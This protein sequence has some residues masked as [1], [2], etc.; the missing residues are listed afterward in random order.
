MNDVKSPILFLLLGALIIAGCDNADPDDSPVTSGILV[1]NQGNFSDGN[2]SV[3]LIDLA[4]SN[5]TTV[6]DGLA[7]IVQSLELGDSTFHVVA[8]TGGRV[9]V[10]SI[11]TGQRVGQI[12]G[13]T[14]PRY[15]ASLATGTAY[16]SNLFGAGFS[17]GTVSI[18]DLALQTVVKTIDVGNNPEGVAI[19]GG[20]VYVANNE[21][22]AG[23]TL[24]VISTTTQEV[25]GT[26]DV[27]CDGPRALAVDRE[28]EL[29][30][31][32]TG[33]T[34]YDNNFNVIGET[35]GEI[36]L[37]DGA[38]GT[39]ITRFP[40]TSRIGTAGPGQDAYYS[41]EEQ[42]LHVVLDQ[43]KVMR[44][45]TGANAIVD[46][47]GPYAGDPIGAVAYDAERDRLYLARVPG[48]TTAGTV[49]VLDRNGIELGSHAVGIA[50]GHLELVRIDQ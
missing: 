5:V 9:D 24:S 15:M 26:I 47:F 32:C 10:H 12:A 11:T 28:A 6:A 44:I 36:V 17:G 34:L 41:E 21:F 13:L 37:L 45:N 3:M 40:L 48:F 8:N 38:T 2:G 49:T 35:P 46:T 39:I 29:W 16:V 30:V 31:M 20:R 18:V 43:N 25:T 1:A 4:S 23:R 22:G 14:S 42:E 27:E 33:Q 50:P 7:S 19:V